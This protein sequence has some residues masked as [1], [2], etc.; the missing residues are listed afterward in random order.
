MMPQATLHPSTA[1]SSCRAPSRPS[2]S[3]TMPAPR[4]KVSVMMR[5]NRTSARLVAGSRYRCMSEE[6]PSAL[7]MGERPRS[8]PDDVRIEADAAFFTHLV[9]ALYF[10][11]EPRES[12]AVLLE[13]QE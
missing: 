5:P 7:L 2:F 8:F 9:N 12:V 1:T 11:G 4:V 3:T 10:V 6:W 13:C